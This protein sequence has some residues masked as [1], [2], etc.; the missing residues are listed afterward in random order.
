VTAPGKKVLLD[1]PPC[2]LGTAEAPE[3]LITIVCLD[4]G[5]VG[6]TG[7]QST[8]GGYETPRPSRRDPGAVYA[9][10]WEVGVRLVSVVER[11][12][13]LFLMHINSGRL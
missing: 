2:L 13:P 9:G 6:D 12:H 4:N 5:A 8:G 3:K 10:A 1:H 11:K 7:N